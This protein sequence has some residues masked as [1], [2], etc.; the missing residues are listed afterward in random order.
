MCHHTLTSFSRAV[1]RMPTALMMT[2]GIMITTITASTRYQLSL[3][4]SPKMRVTAPMMYVA[5]AT[6]MPAVIVTWPIMLSHAV[7]HAQPRPPS[8]NAQK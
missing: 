2:W 5:A 4:G 1:S 3:V 8:R 7:S 6:L